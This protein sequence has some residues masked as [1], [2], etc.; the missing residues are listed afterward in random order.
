M[1]EPIDI[2]SLDPLYRDVFRDPANGTPDDI[3]KAGCLA[4]AKLGKEAWNAWR[5]QHPVL[6]NIKKYAIKNNANFSDLD[7]KNLYIDF[8]HFS[9]GDYAN[10]EKVN[11]YSQACF[12]FAKFGEQVNFSD[13]QAESLNFQYATFS[14]AAI[15]K[16]SLAIEWATFYGAKFFGVSIFTGSQFG[17]INF[18]GTHFKESANFDAVYFQDDVDFS[19]G[20]LSQTLEVSAGQLNVE[21]EP[22]ADSFA[23]IDFAGAKFLKKVV[24]NGRIFKG[25][26]GFGRLIVVET[27]VRAK[28]EVAN[29]ITLRIWHEIVPALSPVHFADVPQLHGCQIH[30]D[31]TFEDAIFPLPSG[32]NIDIRAYRTLK[33]AFS[34]QQAIR[35][36]QRFFK[37]EMAEEAARATGTHRFLYKAYF[38]CSDYGFSIT[39]P[40]VLL[41]VTLAAMML[42]YG[43][44]SYLNNCLPDANNCHFSTAWIEFSLLQSLPLPG[45]DKLSDT[46]RGKLFPTEGLISI[47]VT[48]AVILHKAISL[49]ALFLMGLALRNLFK[50]K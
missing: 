37:L 15:F 29:G 49:L 17:R 9:F 33:L 13:I 10:F 25:F 2:E 38:L 27:V 44:L 11:F 43:V 35:E 16:R 50:L 24:F 22:V 47:G 26:T 12:R 30:Q 1:T 18:V 48:V 20:D 42:I 46:L 7:L 6:S 34:Q 32:Y 36:E 23:Y 31:T 45:L 39:R 8:S 19:A 4:L 3:S 41:A 40:A 28:Y 14:G 21:S 5:E